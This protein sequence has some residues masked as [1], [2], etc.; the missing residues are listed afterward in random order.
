MIILRIIKIQKKLYLFI[1]KSIKYSRVSHL[2]LKIKILFRL[3]GKISTVSS[4]SMK[5]M[6][7]LLY[8]ENRT[9]TLGSRMVPPPGLVWPWPLTFAYEI[10]WHNVLYIYCNTCLSGL[11]KNRWIVLKMSCQKGYL[12]PLSARMTLTSDVLTPNLI[13]LCHF[14]MD[15]VCQVASTSV[16]TLSMYSV[17]KFRNGRMD[18]QVENIMPQPVSLVWRAAEA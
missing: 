17:H 1:W 3:K 18:R 2:H 14:P 9:A 8:T 5:W 15:H 13:V 12:W 7:Y 11:V 16:Y 6:N 4:S 10:L